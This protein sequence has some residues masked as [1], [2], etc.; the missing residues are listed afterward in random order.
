MDAYYKAYDKRYRQ[1]HENDVL[2]T[3]FIPTLEVM[4]VIDKYKIDKNSKIL[5]LGCGEG[6]DSIHLL[7][8]KYNVLG[9]DYSSEAI[10]TCNKLSEGK[11]FN[12]FKQFDIMEDIMHE[13]FDFIYSISVLNMFVEDIH[14][15]KFL[16][17]IYNHLTDNGVAFISIIGDGEEMYSSNVE[18]AFVDSNCVNINTD[19]EMNIAS[20]TCCIVDWESFVKELDNS[21]LVIKSHWISDRIP[22]FNLSMCVVVGKK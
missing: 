18:D 3:S 15:K 19:Q 8:Q 1:V 22:D 9:I 5:E 13:K 10:N 16:D 4:D 20:T 2:W 6:R 7:K 12:N 17:F 11:F 14:R 21:K